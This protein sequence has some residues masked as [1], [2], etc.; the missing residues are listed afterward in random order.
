M[1]FKPHF[2]RDYRRAV[3]SL[4]R[5]HDEHTAM[6]LAVGGSYEIA[7]KAQLDVLRAIGLHD[8]DMLVDVGCGSGRT[9]FALRGLPIRYHGIDVVPDL[10]AYAK[11][12]AARADWRFSVVE[13]L[14]IPEPDATADMVVFF[15][16]LTHL[17]WDEG[18]TYLS[19]AL[20]VLKPGGTLMF[21]FLD[22]D[23]KRH[24]QMAGSWAVQAYLRLR[25]R[26]VK[27]VTLSHDQITRWAA[28]RG[29]AITFHGPEAF[30]QSYCV[31][32]RS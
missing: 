22:R 21:S 26:G 23:V 7:G 32:R 10:V 20:R 25:G 31:A 11:A 19:D 8:G 17:T 27:N 14:N 28:H 12:K 18:Q 1:L 29:L 3:R 15:S 16:V 4:R 30:G 2:V 13:G 9:A 5:N 6:S 24:R